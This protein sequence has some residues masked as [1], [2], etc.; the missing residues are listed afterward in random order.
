MGSGLAV[1]AGCKSDS[2]TAPE[3]GDARLHS[4][5]TSPTATAP[6]GGVTI[7]I[8]LGLDGLAYF[9]SSYKSTTPA[10]VALLLHGTGQAPLDIL[11]PIVPY[12]D[13]RALI[14]AAITASAGTWDGVTGNFGQDIRNIDAALSWL[15][16]RSNVDARRV[17]VAGFSDGGSY[18]IGLARANGDLFKRACIYSPG[19]LISIRE[20]GKPEFFV[21][22]GTQ[23]QVLSF[24]NTKNVIV[25]TL[26]SD[27]YSVDFYQFDGGHGITPELLEQ[28]IDWF[29]RT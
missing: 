26:K 10:P 2:I 23:D 13:K 1:L 20:V 21:T 19:V 3:N 7:P 8:T 6:V 25:P 17:G 4:R 5:P 12:A 28:S 9:P 16:E 11:G 18:A 29:V 14:L 24:D 15:F 22:H 27:G